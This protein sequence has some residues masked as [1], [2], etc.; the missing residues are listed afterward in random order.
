MR[1]EAFTLRG[2]RVRLRPFNLAD[3]PAL[4]EIQRVNQAAFHPYMPIRNETFFTLDG[5]R[6][7]IAQDRDRAGHDQGYALAVEWDGRIIGRV[8]L[9]NVVRGAWQNATLGYWI[10][11]R[12]QGQGFATEAVS[13]MLKAAFQILRLHR[14]QAAIMPHNLPSLAVVKK[15]GF[16]Y[17]GRAPRYLCIAGQWED[18]EIFSLTVED[19]KE[20]LGWE[21][22]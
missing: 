22:D 20:P 19:F 13:G 7:A 16:T 14:V 1:G 15:L 4:L 9:S 6:Q 10:D 11:S 17:E 18:H 8:A 21:I 2:P 12:F 3:A 5:Q